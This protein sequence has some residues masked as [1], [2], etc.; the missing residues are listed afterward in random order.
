MPDGNVEQVRFIVSEAVKQAHALAQTEAKETEAPAIP[1]ILKWIAGIAAV[2]VAAV[3]L[4]YF[5]WLTDT[6]TQMQVTLARMDERQASQ[7]AAAENRYEDMNR[8]VTRLEGFHEP[9]SGQ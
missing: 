6:V 1:T 5:N 2:I 7:V 8:R 4:G 3:I 9:E